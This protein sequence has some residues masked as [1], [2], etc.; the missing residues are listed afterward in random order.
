ME[1]GFKEMDYFGNGACLRRGREESVI[2]PSDEGP[3]GDVDTE[4]EK[5]EETEKAAEPEKAA[6][7]EKSAEL[8]E[9][10][11]PEKNRELGKD[12]KSGENILPKIEALHGQLLEKL[13]GMEALFC[14]RIM[15]AEYEDKV[16]DQLHSELQKY[17]DDL[18][19]QMIRPILLDVIDVRESILTVAE[20]SRKK[21]EGEQSISVAQFADYANDLQGILERND[22]EL[23]RG[24]EGEPYIPIKQRVVKKEL[25]GDK[26]LHGKICESLSYGYSYRGKTIFPE[27]ITAYYYGEKQT[28]KEESEEAANG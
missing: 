27:K 19:F 18:Y 8:E 4:S 15:H 17:K 11:E 6:E 14:K 24:K 25:T 22:V 23:Y 2:P 16:I 20:A 7:T 13:S 10:E 3:E 9:I 26:E 1:D 21:A 12:M 28:E 5:S